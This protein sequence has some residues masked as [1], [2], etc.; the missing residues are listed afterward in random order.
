MSE[1]IGSQLR[2]I[3]GLRFK[4]VRLAKGIRCEHVRGLEIIGGTWSEVRPSAAA[5]KDDFDAFHVN[6]LDLWSEPWRPAYDEDLSKHVDVFTKSSNGMSFP[7]AAYPQGFAVAHPDTGFGG[8]KV[9]P[10]SGDACSVA[11]IRFD[12][13]SMTGA[14]GCFSVRDAAG[15]CMDVA[16]SKRSAIYRLAWPFDGVGKIL[17]SFPRKGVSTWRTNTG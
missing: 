14:P 16:V 1:A 12:E 4:D 3:E 7:E 2:P 13:S 8:V 15:V 10:C 17:V 5:I 11:D 6:R 9:M